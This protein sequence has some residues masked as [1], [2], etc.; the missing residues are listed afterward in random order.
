MTTN[1][2]PDHSAYTPYQTRESNGGTQERYRFANG[3]GASVIIG[4]PYAYGGL[5][6]AVIGPDGKLCYDTPI[7]SDVLG[8]LSPSEVQPLLAAIAA[9]PA[10]IA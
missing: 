10:V 1:S 6:L 3:Y 7:T 2:S 9:L 8:Y 4:G 5:E